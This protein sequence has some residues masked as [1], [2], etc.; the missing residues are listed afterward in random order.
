MY[1]IF[2]YFMMNFGRNPFCFAFFYRFFN[3][4]NFNFF[5]LWNL[6]TNWHEKVQYSNRVNQLVVHKYMFVHFRKRC[7]AAMQTHQRAWSVAYYFEPTKTRKKNNNKPKITNVN[8][9]FSARHIVEYQ[10]KK[11]CKGDPKIV[12]IDIFSHFHCALF[13][14]SKHQPVTNGCTR[15]K[16]VYL[17]LKIKSRAKVVMQYQKIF[18]GKLNIHSFVLLI[19]KK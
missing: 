7:I 5:V 10:C 19:V 17:L 4:F 2:S 16:I 3:F 8:N 13:M 15:N 9:T 14:L 12:F 1:N 6:L 11:R 18:H